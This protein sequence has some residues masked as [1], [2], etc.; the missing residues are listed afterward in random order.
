MPHAARPRPKSLESPCL[1]LSSARKPQLFQRKRHLDDVSVL[2]DP[3]AS[4]PDHVPGEILDAVLLAEDGVG[5]H[6]SRVDAELKR[7]A[8]VI[9]RVDHHAHVVAL[10][11]RVGIVAAHERR[12]D[13][14][15]PRIVRAKRHVE[16]GVVVGDEAL[17]GDGRRHVVAGRPFV[18]QGDDRGLLPRGLIEHAVDLDRRGGA[19]RREGGDGRRDAR[20]LRRLRALLR[21]GLGVRRRC[22]RHD[23]EREDTSNRERRHQSPLSRL[24]GFQ[25]R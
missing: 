17:G 5:L 7:T 24:D 8:F 22:M 6:A 3:G 21:G 13:F 23:D 19:H 20:G 11:E 15:G 9:E 16:V 12:A 2:S 10:D 25:R 14:L 18:R 1:G 4:V